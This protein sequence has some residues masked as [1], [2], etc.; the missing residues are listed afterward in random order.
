MATHHINEELSIFAHKNISVS[1]NNIF[2]ITAILVV[3]IGAAHQSCSIN[4]I[5]NSPNP[6]TVFYRFNTSIRNMQNQMWNN[7]RN[8]LRRKQNK[9]KRCKCFISVDETYDSYTGKIHKKPIKDL[10]ENEKAIRKYIHK[11]KIKR[12]DTGSFKYL[13]F[14]L[15]Y[16][17]K[18]R[19]LYVKALR[20]KES[21]WKFVATTLLKIQK[22]L[23]FE[24]AL[25]DRGFYVSDLIN[26]LEKHNIPY[27]I[28][29]KISDSMKK[30]FGFFKKWRSYEY[31]VADNANT[32][33]ILGRDKF[34]RRWAF[35]SNCSNLFNIRKQYAKRWD[36]ENIFKATDGI[37]LKVSTAPSG[38]AILRRHWRAPGRR[39]GLVDVCP[40]GS[41]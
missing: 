16:G 41:A 29:A 30:Y 26:E 12:G 25:L 28:R 7:S 1:D 19:V 14:A 11:Y 27:I 10:S 13:V 17:N 32:N 23:K 20:R 3:L 39:G 15:T 18:R 33:L 9:F 4:S 35:V 24:A 5:T 22:E 36:I 38:G 8:F 6:D 2:C 34:Y 21:Y 37:Q 31:S 40:A